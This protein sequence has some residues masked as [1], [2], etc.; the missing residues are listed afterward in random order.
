MARTRHYEFF[1]LQIT[2]VPGYVVIGS[3]GRRRLTNPAMDMSWQTPVPFWAKR[4]LAAA[5]RA[6]EIGRKEPK[7]EIARRFETAIEDEIIA[8]FNHEMQ[9]WLRARLDEMNGYKAADYRE[10]PK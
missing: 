4:R 3:D 1:D 5:L 2:G 8:A 7:W 6:I 9:S 10:D